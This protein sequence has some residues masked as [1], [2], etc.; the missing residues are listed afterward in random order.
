MAI[1]SPMKRILAK[2]SNPSWIFGLVLKASA[3]ADAP[4]AII[5]HQIV[6][7]TMNVPPRKRKES[8][9]Y[10]E[11]GSMNDGRNAMKKS[12]TF[13]FS[14]FVRNPCRY[15]T[16]M[17]VVGTA[18][19]KPGRARLLCIQVLMPSQM[20]YNAPSRIMAANATGQSA[21]TA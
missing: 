4:S 7:V 5:R 6:P 10:V 3:N 1:P 17:L 19:A 20:R 16:Y 15:T 12:A 21:R 2:R 11:T 18:A 14:R 13:G 8:A 9:P